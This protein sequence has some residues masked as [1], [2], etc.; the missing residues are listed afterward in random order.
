VRG[1]ALDLDSIAIVVGNDGD[2]AVGQNSVNVVEKHLDAASAVLRG[3]SFRG[4]LKM[5]SKGREQRT[6]NSEQLN[7]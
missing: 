4:H 6:V 5:V 7:E 2:I 3:E 1:E